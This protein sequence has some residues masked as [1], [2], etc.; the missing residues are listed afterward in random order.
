[1][2]FEND[3]SLYL[4]NVQPVQNLERV[5]KPRVSFLNLGESDP[6][7]VLSDLN[8]GGAMAGLFFEI[9]KNQKLDSPMTAI[10]FAIMAY[11]I[12]MDKLSGMD[13]DLNY[14]EN[15]AEC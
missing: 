10:L 4:E 6:Y 14:P 15:L 12:F 9:T 11:G 2:E 5:G 13:P 3:L 8:V 7:S 1:M